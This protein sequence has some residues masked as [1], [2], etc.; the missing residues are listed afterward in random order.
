MPLR[1]AGLPRITLPQAERHDEHHDGHPQGDAEQARETAQHP[2]LGSGG[3]QQHVAGPRRTG[4]GNREHEEGDGLLWL[5]G[6][7]APAIDRLAAWHPAIGRSAGEGL[8]RSCEDGDWVVASRPGEGVELLRAWFGGRAYARHRHDTYAIGVTDAGVQTFDYRGRVE[9]SLPGQI[10][11]L[12]PD[13]MHDGRPGTDSGFGYRIVY[14]DPSRIADAIRT[15]SGSPTPLPFVREPVSDN[16]TLA[17]A[18][19]AAFRCARSPWPSTPWCSAWRKASPRPRPLGTKCAPA[20][21][22]PLRAR[23]RPCAPG[24]PARHRAVGGAR[25]DHGPGPLRAGPPVPR[26]LR[27]ESLP[28]IRSCGGSISRETSYATGHRWPSSPWRPA[29]STRRTSHACSD[30]PSESRRA[31]MRG[32]ARRRP[33]GAAFSI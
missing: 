27:D 18:V 4:R 22:R 14:V 20:S 30:R 6:N 7:P 9:R 21:P 24:W 29:L 3:G 15:I 1:T 13:E 25:N 5:H 23:E 11:V 12:H 16:P 26:R 19:A 2:D 28:A 31:A 17:R 33:R 10:V 32:S 8:V